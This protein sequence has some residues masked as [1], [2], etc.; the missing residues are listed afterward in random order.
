MPTPTRLPAP[1][2]PSRSARCGLLAI[3]VIL[4]L[5]PAT[6]RGQEDD[7]LRFGITVGG[8]SFAGLSLEFFQGARSLELSVGTWAARDL[9]V[10]LVGR[11]YFGAGSMKPT[12]GLGFWTVVAWPED[13]RTGVA[14]VARA[15]VGFDWNPGGEHFL[16]FDIN[17]NQGV[18]VRRSDPEDLAP[19]THRLVP[20]PGFAYRWRP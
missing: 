15:P 2:H 11:E 3:L 8:T 14:L 1:S 13:G 17:V 20:L 16:A 7:G 6:A 9:T 12:V 19:M 10:S 18:W 5:T 4:L